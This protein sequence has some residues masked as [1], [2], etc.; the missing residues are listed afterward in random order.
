MG[1][2]GYASINIPQYRT[3]YKVD[4]DHYS[5]TANVKLSRDSAPDGEEGL[6]KDDPSLLSPTQW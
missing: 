3:R 1:S 5:R 4:N 6:V 2:Y